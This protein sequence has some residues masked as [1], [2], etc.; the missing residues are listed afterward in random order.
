MNALSRRQ[1]LT[2]SAALGAG[3]LVSRF[4][5]A[6]D[7]P[8]TAKLVAGNT[9]F[10]CELYG[11]LRTEA[12]NLFLSPFSI[13]TAL[14][15]TAAGA[16]GKTLEEMEKVLH[17]P[18]NA[19][20]CFGAVLK[21]LNDEPDAKKRGFTLTTANALWAQ[22]GYPWRPEYKK[23]VATDFGAGLFD[24]DFKSAAEA[25]RATINA[26]VEKET[27]EKIKNLLPQGTV[28]NLTRLVLTNAIYFKG[29]WQDKFEKANTKNLPFTA[30]DGKKTDVPLM[31]R[32]G[33]YLYAETDSYQ[34]LDLP[35]AGKRVSMTVI[36]PKRH[37]TLPGIEK[38]LSGEK[39]TAA[40][41]SLQF[42]KEV[43]VYLPKFKAEKFFTLN[44]PLQALGMKAAFDAA[45]FGGMAA[46]VMLRISAV[47]HKA[48]VDVNEEGTEAAAGTAVVVAEPSA[49]PQPKVFRADRPFLYLIRDHKTASV[50]FL[51]RLSEPP[52]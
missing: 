1:F 44:E 16:R 10:G 21:S 34:V 35:Y 7:K 32:T 33:S 12:G 6:E 11:Q 18:A 42:E 28:T 19:P 15:M 14:A 17:L 43:R 46:G 3:A 29:D 51:G 37:N 31:H 27:R 8:D 52:K 9:A 45:D 4:G 36:L 41:R 39:L 5:F 49:P 30:A 48:F 13:S 40:L 25:A 22:Q 26:W 24:V 20:A 47:L 38:D 2:A 23:L 50:L